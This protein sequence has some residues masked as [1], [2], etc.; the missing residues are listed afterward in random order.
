MGSNSDSKPSEKMDDKS[1]MIIYVHKI[2]T[3]DLGS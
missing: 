1:S 2:I 3:K